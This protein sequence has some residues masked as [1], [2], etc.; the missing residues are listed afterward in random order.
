MG[1]PTT[2]PDEDIDTVATN[3]QDGGDQPEAEHDG[4][5]ENVEDVEQEDDADEADD[6]DEDA[7]EEAGA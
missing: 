3:A 7:D 5:A 1:D 4:E 2:T 6:A